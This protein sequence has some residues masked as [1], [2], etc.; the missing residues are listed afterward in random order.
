[1]ADE[2]RRAGDGAAAALGH[3]VHASVDGEGR[4][5]RLP[6]DVRRLLA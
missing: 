4:P 6:D 5:A 3:T 2:V 1:L